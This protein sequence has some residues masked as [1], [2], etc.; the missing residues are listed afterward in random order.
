MMT[1]IMIIAIVMIM[2]Y[3]VRFSGCGLGPFLLP[4]LERPHIPYPARAGPVNELTLLM[5]TYPSRGYELVL[6]LDLALRARCACGMRLSRFRGDRGVLP[7]R[8]SVL[9]RRSK[10]SVSM[11]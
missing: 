6:I 5:M 10:R 7:G 2:I 11:R 4:V 9:R 3:A 8:L 1:S